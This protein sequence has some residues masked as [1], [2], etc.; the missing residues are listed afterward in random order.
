MNALAPLIIAATGIP[1]LCF[2]AWSGRPGTVHARGLG[3]R[4]ALIALC[5]FV[6]AVGVYLAGDNRNIAYG[7]VIALVIAV[8]ALG[9]S[10]VVHLRRE[11]NG[12]PRK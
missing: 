11:R 8:N 7:V 1:A 12:A 10:L 2:A 9:I 4:W 3:L 5:L 6:G